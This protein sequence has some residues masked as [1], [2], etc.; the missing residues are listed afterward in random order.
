[1]SVQILRVVLIVLS[2]IPLATGLNGIV[3]GPPGL[4]EPTTATATLDS[5]YRFVNVFWL[6]AGGVLFWSAWQVVERAAAARFVP[7]LAA[8]GGLARLWSAVQTDWPHPIFIG[9]IVLELVV[10]P[11]VIWWHWRVT[12]GG[13]RR[14]SPAAQLQQQGS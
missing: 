13:A 5:E 10:V 4:P 6:G 11:A 1:M 2:L 8:L 9:T 7:V 12:R 3:Q 14:L